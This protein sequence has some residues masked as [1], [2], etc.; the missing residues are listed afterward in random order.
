MADVRGARN[1]LC[2]PT[3]GDEAAALG[4]LLEKR[5]RGLHLAVC[6][7]PVRALRAGVRRYDVPA[8]GVELELAER[9][10]DDGRRRLG[11]T[12]PGELALGR[13]RNPRDARSAVSGGFADEEDHGAS[14]LLE[15]C[16]QP[17]AAHIGSV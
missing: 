13:E 17:A 7:C 10:L 2:E 11:R 16:A 8:Q 12:T 9:S 5:P 1:P 14:S 4:Q 3:D 6:R 15:I